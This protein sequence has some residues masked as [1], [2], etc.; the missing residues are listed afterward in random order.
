MHYNTETINQMAEQME[1]MFHLAITGQ[2][3][4]DGNTPTIAQIET[5]I[6]KAL[7]QVG[8]QALC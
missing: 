6:R 2:Q 7:R 1:E 4:S 8:N 3:E 5:D